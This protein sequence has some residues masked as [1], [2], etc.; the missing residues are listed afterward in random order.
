MFQQQV[1]IINTCFM[2]FDAICVIVAGYSAFFLRKMAGGRP[3]SIDPDIFLAS[4]LIVICAN[5]YFMGRFKL[6]GDQ[7]IRSHLEL[8]TSIFKAVTLD[9]TV[10]SAGI[11]FLK[12]TN[13]SRMF[14]LFFAVLTFLTMYVQ[15]LLAY[16]YINKISSYKIYSF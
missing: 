10:V 3:F 6:Y 9:F 1:Q 15:R 12:L 4:I 7:K 16:I 13:Y 5:N 11:V 2:I 8:I 14:L